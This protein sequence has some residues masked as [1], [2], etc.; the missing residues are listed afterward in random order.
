M[1]S[2]TAFPSAV[3]GS[4][5]TFLVGE[6][7]SQEARDSVALDRDPQLMTCSA[8]VGALAFLTFWYARV[9]INEGPHGTTFYRCICLGGLHGELG[10]PLI[11]HGDTPA[12]AI[13]ACARAAGW[14]G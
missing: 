13:M 3:E 9:E 1:N 11:G 10:T 4:N 5:V 6:V 8:R 12:L 14:P 7:L 2:R